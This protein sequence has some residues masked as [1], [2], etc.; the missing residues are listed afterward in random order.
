MYNVKIDFI[1]QRST[2]RVACRDFDHMMLVCEQF[3]NARYVCRIATFKNH[4]LI[5]VVFDASTR[6]LEWC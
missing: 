3:R 5:H 2:T 1:D 6:Y 4:R